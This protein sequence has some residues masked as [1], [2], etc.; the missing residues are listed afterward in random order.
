[1]SKKEKLSKKKF[2]KNQK[3]FLILS[4][5]GTVIGSVSFAI[6]LMLTNSW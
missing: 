3:K 4:F 2:K 6:I 5:G 1:M